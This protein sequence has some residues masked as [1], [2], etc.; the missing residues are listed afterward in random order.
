[1]VALTKTCIPFT[2][3]K[4]VLQRHGHQM[5]SVSCMHPADRR[6]RMGRKRGCSFVEISV[7]GIE[8]KGR[9]HHQRELGAQLLSPKRVPWDGES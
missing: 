3:K 9:K 8:G 7:I 1:M 4:K 5:D 6:P 2:S